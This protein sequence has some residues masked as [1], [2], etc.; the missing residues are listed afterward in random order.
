MLGLM[1]TGKGPSPRIPTLSDFLADSLR[2]M[3]ERLF[4]I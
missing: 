1:V 2:G 4:H 3:S